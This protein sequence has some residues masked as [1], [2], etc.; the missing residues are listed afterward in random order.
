[1]KGNKLTI[2]AVGTVVILGLAMLAVNNESSQVADIQQNTK[3]FPDLAAKMNSV[4]SIAVSQGV[5]ATT[6]TLIDGEWRVV[7]SDNYP[8]DVSKIKQTIIKMS[9]FEIIEAKTSKEA[10][11]A[12]LGVEDPVSKDAKSKLITLSDANAV[13][14]ASLIV[15]HQR[16]TNIA[17][18]S[19]DSLY[20]RKKQDKQSWLVKGELYADLKPRDWIQSELFSIEA[21]RITKMVVTHDAK[22]VVTILK[23][24]PGDAEFTLQSIPKKKVIRSIVDI[25]AMA[26]AVQD[27]IIKEVKSVNNER[28]V[29]FDS[30]A[31]HAEL[32]TFDGLV[33]SVDTIR[34]GG[35]HY[36]KFSI[37]YDASLRL[38]L[39]ATAAETMKTPETPHAE[40]P[41][42]VKDASKTESEAAALQKKFD[43][44]VFVISDTKSDNLRKTMG[45]LVKDI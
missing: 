23:E 21:N 33:L 16:S 45:D 6:V 3:L 27:I 8:A 42:L 10:N 37:K 1:M 39:P 19:T 34:K 15:G 2:L 40:L 5:K 32:T 35:K 41:A 29:S 24:R 20:V 14:V 44:W 43:S 4:T 31:I 28:A 7:E 13:E 18:A 9:D 22:N 12:K 17:S 25:N 38:Q 36:A 26:E 30:G 11:Y